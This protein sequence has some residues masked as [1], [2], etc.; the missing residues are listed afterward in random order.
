[1][2]DFWSKVNGYKTVLGTVAAV[3][4]VGAV[5][6]GLVGQNQIV[7]YIITVVLGVG[8]SHKAVKADS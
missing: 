1:M 7:E 3:L 5:S 2:E 4:Y 6:Q 8:L